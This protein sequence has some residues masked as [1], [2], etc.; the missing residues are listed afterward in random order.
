MPSKKYTVACPA[1][2]AVQHKTNSEIKKGLP[3]LFSQVQEA[4]GVELEN[5]VYVKNNVSHYFV[6]SP[7]LACL[8]QTGVVIDSKCLNLLV[9]PLASLLL[10]AMRDVFRL[11]EQLMVPFV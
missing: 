7:T 2:D 1:P 4:T 3:D 8:V 10:V 11:I 6:M 5:I 9:S